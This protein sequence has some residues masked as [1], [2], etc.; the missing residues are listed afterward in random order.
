MQKRE[1]INLG[2]IILHSTGC[3][4]C[5]VLKKKLS[6]KGI[7]YLENNNA[8][9]MMRLGITNVPVLEVDEVKME[10]KD[11]VEWIKER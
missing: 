4:K 10:F 7:S 8:E 9:E 1:V 6:E 2:K 11:A 3:P 5:N